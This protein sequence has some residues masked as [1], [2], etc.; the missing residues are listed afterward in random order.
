LLTN[1]V[2]LLRRDELVMVQKTASNQYR[3]KI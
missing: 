1:D 3:F 2:T